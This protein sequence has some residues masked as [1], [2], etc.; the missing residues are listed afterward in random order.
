MPVIGLNKQAKPLN[1]ILSF[2]EIMSIH[3]HTELM[4]HT[5]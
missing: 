5:S 3:F 1:K 2:G 4:P